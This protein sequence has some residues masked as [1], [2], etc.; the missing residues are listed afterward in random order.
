MGVAV[1][2]NYYP[3]L[4]K[5]GLT[6]L[7]GLGRIK[8]ESETWEE[9]INKVNHKVYPSLEVIDTNSNEQLAELKRFFEKSTKKKKNTAKPDVVAKPVDTTNVKINNDVVA[10]INNTETNNLA[11]MIKELKCKIDGSCKEVE[12]MKETLNTMKKNQIKGEDM[13]NNEIKK[14][15]NKNVEPSKGTA[16][17]MESL[18]KCIID[19][20]CEA[21]VLKDMQSK[22]STLKDE[23]EKIKSE[24]PSVVTDEVKAKEIVEP[25]IELPSDKK[26]EVKSEEPKK[27]L[28]EQV[29]CMLDGTCSKIDKTVDEK[30]KTIAEQ[31][32]SKIDGLFY[33]P[34]AKKT[35]EKDDKVVD[36]KPEVKADESVEKPNDQTIERINKI[37]EKL[38]SKLE[39]SD[40]EVEP[41]KS[42]PAMTDDTQKT[43]EPAPTNDVDPAIKSN[44][45]Y[46]VVYGRR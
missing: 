22:I 44:P 29:K 34:K 28:L 19:G 6:N 1:G 14:T 42:E 37:L 35:I 15:E 26:P 38:E 27:D 33:K 31:L 17:T 11:A 7:S 8:G 21:P 43:V 10:K 5:A 25:K 2:L 40:K 3:A 36:E 12:S 9:F 39:S 46:R 45:L 23:I 41:S 20:V 30:V 13:S 4:L 16:V 24:K 32:N 18:K